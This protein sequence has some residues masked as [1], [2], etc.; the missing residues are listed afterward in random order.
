MP[1]RVVSGVDNREG[2]N[3]RVCSGYSSSARDI[4]LK[5]KGKS[6]VCW[7]CSSCG[8]S[9]GQ[10]WGFCQSCGSSGTLTEFT[11]SD[12]ASNKK[13][14][15]VVSEKA[16][17]SWLP[18]Q[19][20]EMSPQRLTDVKKGVNQLKWRIPLSGLFGAEVARVL[21][22]GLVP[23]SMVLVGGDP[24]VGKSTLLLQIAA[25]LA[26]RHDFAPPAP[27]LYVS[28]E[29]SIEQIGNRADRMRIGTE[30]LFLYS[31][32]DIEDILE[33]VQKLCPRALIVDSIQTVY[34]KGVTG[35]PGGLPQVKECT[36]ALLCFAKR[37][38]IPILV[39]GHVTKTG[40][41]AGPRVLEHIVDVVL[42][43]EVGTSLH[44]Y[45]TYIRFLTY[46][47]LGFPFHAMDP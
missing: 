23:G 39:I 26:E 47:Y 44:C 41:I 28:G 33:K 17:R 30:E 4:V 5:K 37:T 38:N 15:F 11:Q 3:E 43:L 6:K 31:S 20:G 2:G 1:N 8:E 36:T 42:Y 32:T 13:T 35:S 34:L 16:V 46:K 9:F 40:D 24:G 22:G 21:G 45:P 18:Q 25:M 19:P 7:V 27:V 29:E 10:W 14:G 12:D